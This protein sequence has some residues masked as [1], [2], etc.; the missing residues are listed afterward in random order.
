MLCFWCYLAWFEV[1][2]LVLTG[3]VALAKSFNLSKTQFPYVLKEDYGC[4]NLIELYNLNEIIYVK[5]LAWGLAYKYLKNVKER[6]KIFDTRV[7]KAI[8]GP[9][10]S[11]T[12]KCS[13]KGKLV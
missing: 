12:G 13:N 4:T 2:P 8:V 5:S 11:F 10:F 1:S 3:C 9:V 6:R 7:G